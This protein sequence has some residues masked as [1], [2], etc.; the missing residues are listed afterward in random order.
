[1]LIYARIVLF[2]AVSD[3][4]VRQQNMGSNI[5]DL[6][7]QWAAAI[8]LAERPAPFS[9]RDGSILR[10]VPPNER[11]SMSQMQQHLHQL[12]Q[13]EE[14][15]LADFRAHSPLI[16]NSSSSRT[17]SKCRGEDVLQFTVTVLCLDIV[18]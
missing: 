14:H 18:S 16:P 10:L 2:F 5:D 12:L 15:M 3:W 6:A 7:A 11:L 1:V 9:S 4:L 13:Q 17:G 8:A